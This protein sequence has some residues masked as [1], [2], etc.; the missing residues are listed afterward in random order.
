MTE[1]GGRS[2][3]YGIVVFRDARGASQAIRCARRL[4]HGATHTAL[5]NLHDP[6]CIGHFS[7]DVALPPS[8]SASGSPFSYARRLYTHMCM[9][10]LISSP[11]P[12]LLR[13]LC[14]HTTA[15]LCTVTRVYV[16]AFVSCFP[17]PVLLS[18]LF[19]R[20]RPVFPSPDVQTP[21]S[22]VGSPLP[23][24]CVSSSGCS[25]TRSC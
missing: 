22:G 25:T 24:G 9:F 1:P 19:S 5:S 18:D 4:Q 2:K 13:D 15:L 12:S 11:I 3:G 16:R 20:S 23:I 14:L 7:K 10:I 6:G 17:S 8:L 21:P